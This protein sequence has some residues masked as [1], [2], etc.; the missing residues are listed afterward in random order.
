MLIPMADIA[1]LTRHPER[2]SHERAA[3]DAILDAGRVAT[4]CTVADGE[5]WVVPMLYGRY[6]DRVVIHGSTG[7]G[8]LRAVAA[9]A[10]VA[11]CVTHLDGL[12]YAESLFESSANYRSAVL[13]GRVVTLTGDEK[14]AALDALSDRVMPGRR[15]ELRRHTAKELASTLVVA[16]PITA[17]SWTVKSRSGPPLTPEEESDTWRGVLPIRLVYGAPQTAPDVASGTPVAPSV[18]ALAGGPL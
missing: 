9:G 6:G 13:R 15:G 18:V 16:L 11:V 7:A 4:V 1:T 2:G 17:A 10:P 14:V 5:P 12:V 8:L 3:L